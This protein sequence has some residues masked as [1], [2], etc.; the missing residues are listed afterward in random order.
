VAVAVDHR[1]GGEYVVR[2]LDQVARF[3][4][5]PQ[6]MRTYQGP[7]FTSRAFKA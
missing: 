6:A 7:E 5:H 2:L 1:A 3:R 4:G